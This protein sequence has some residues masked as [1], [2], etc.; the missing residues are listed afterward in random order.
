[1]PNPAI[2]LA[3]GSIGGALISADAAKDASKQAS[4][5][6]NAALAWEQKQYDDWKAIYGDFEKNLGDYYGSL[7]PAFVE[8]RGIE[9]FNKEKEATLTKV[10]EMFTQRGIRSD[11][12]L[13]ASTEAAVEL[14]SAATKA[15]IRATAKDKVAEQQSKFLSIGMGRNP[16]D[17]VGQALSERASNSASAAS[18]AAT[19]AGSAVGTA[20]RDV[21]TGVADYLRDVDQLGN[22]LDGG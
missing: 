3:G 20:I 6:Q 2:A 4:A 18:S 11:S 8:A 10:R 14:V 19:A 17:R 15:D 13:A 1:M 12:A 21:S 16:A 5:D 7:S 9:A 22:A